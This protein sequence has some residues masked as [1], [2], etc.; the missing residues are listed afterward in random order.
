VHQKA[1]PALIG[2]AFALVAGRGNRAQVVL[3]S[4]EAAIRQVFCGMT[5]AEARA[6]CADL[7]CREYDEELYARQQREIVQRL[8]QASPQV[9]GLESGIFLL[10]AGGLA[11]LG[12][13]SG[14]CRQVQ[15]LICTAGF[16]DLH[17][18]IADTAFAARIASKFKRSRRYI[19]PAGKDR[20]FLLPL[21]LHHMPISREMQETLFALGIK[22]I[23]QL[24]QIPVDE[25]QARFGKEGLLALDLAGGIDNTRPPLL[26]AEVVYESAVDLSFPVESLAQ[27]QFILK[28]MLDSVC[29]RLKE[30]GLLAD[31][32]VIS[33]FCDSDKFDERP[34][35]LIR[36]SSSSKFLLEIIKL[37]LEATPLAREYTGLHIKVQQCSCQSWQ[38]NKMRIV[39]ANEEKLLPVSSRAPISESCQTLVERSQNHATKT[40]VA[41]SNNN[42]TQTEPFILL[43]QRF[44]CR[45]GA[46]SVVR[47]VAC[48][49]H[50]PD[51]SACFL[52]LVEEARSILP[53]NLNFAES[54]AGTSTLAC[55]LILRKSP[56]PQP[57]LIEYQGKIPTSITYQGRWY[58][59]KELTEPE[60]L[61]G[62]WWE[63]PVRKSYYVA[64]IEAVNERVSG[65][66]AGNQ[67]VEAADTFN[68]EIYIVLL[69]HDHISN[70]WQLDG[71][72]D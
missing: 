70:S 29:S 38:Q 37:S 72:F 48:D 67:N 45:L 40:F 28:S 26:Q 3:C 46:K 50:I 61:S 25:L 23:G 51:V 10:D 15:K 16:P 21:S 1:E 2:R 6:V 12:G 49:Q 13:E 24:L 66:R 17:I 68:C 58:R 14:F 27:T 62:L 18:G 34:L 20:E 57:V 59:I 22:T 69:V 54:G 8:V 35:K 55:G 30:N 31:E 19:V 36:P 47:P 63:N 53:V 11:H 42:D 43:L 44:V 65:S 32:L 41:E 52:P 33:F 9:S 7:T 4:R 5:V 71:F 39:E 56:D 60:R 64:L